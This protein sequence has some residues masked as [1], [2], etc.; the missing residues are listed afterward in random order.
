MTDTLSEP[1]VNERLLEAAKF[2]LAESFI[3]D[4]SFG[5]KD[6]LRLAIAA[7]ESERAN[8]HCRSRLLGCMASVQSPKNI[9]RSG[10]LTDATICQSGCG[11]SDANGKQCS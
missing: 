4:Y 8:G 5:L 1:T 2:L 7:A 11:T 3:E 10:G 9:R 6:E